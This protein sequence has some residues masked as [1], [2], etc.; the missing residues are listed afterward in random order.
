MA[1]MGDAGLLVL[2]ATAGGFL[3][4]HGAQKVF[5]VLNGP[6]FQGTTGFMNMLGLRPARAWAVAVGTGELGGGVLTAL[7][8]LNPVGPIGMVAAMA[9]ATQKAHLG[10]GLF[11]SEGGPELTLLNSA[12]ALAVATAGPGAYSLDRAFG[13]RLP[14]WLTTTLALGATATVVYGM[15]QSPEAQPAADE[16][17]EAAEDRGI[18]TGAEAQG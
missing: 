6:G 3:A 5:G 14:R 1:K 7:G 18:A 11:V 12:A 13:V 9:M 17:Q 10:K 15:L 4:A 16:A 2:R 8:F